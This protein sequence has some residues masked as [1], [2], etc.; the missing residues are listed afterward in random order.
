MKWHPA[1]RT[2][3]HGSR[4]AF[5]HAPHLAL[6]GDEGC[7]SCHGFSESGDYLDSYKTFSA[8]AIHSNFKAMDLSACA[9]CHRP[10]LAGDDCVQCHAYHFEPPAVS[11]IA[12][13][14]KR[15]SQGDQ[16]P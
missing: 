14:L 5:S 7:L 2:G 3:T 11:S 4:A 16:R 8:A 10:D 9:E 12:T 6:M 15:E 1:D 13:K